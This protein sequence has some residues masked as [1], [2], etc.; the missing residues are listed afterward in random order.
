MKINR[1]LLPALFALGLVIFPPWASAESHRATRLGNPATS[2]APT[3][4]SPSDLRA[5][6]GSAE[7]HPDFVEILRQW[8]WPGNVDDMFAAAMTNEIVEW[9][10]PVGETMPFMSSREHGRPICLRNVTWAGRDPIHAYAFTFNSNGHNWRCITP[11][12]CSNFFVEDL[13]VA[14]VNALTIDCSAPDKAG[15]GHSIQLCLNVHNTG[16][17]TATN[18]SVGL[19]IP[20][21]AFATDTTDDGIVTNGLVTWIL[22]VLP[23]NSTKEVC[24]A[25][26]TQEPGTVDFSATASSAE[27]APVS[28]TCGTEVK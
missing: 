8:G 10:I 4:Y 25:V 2:F 6:F 16:N 7:L 15:V 13:G 12:P 21:T 1:Y 28:S 9:N 23:A 5:R 26:K 14:T 20:A 27:V 19:T 24:T 22:P 18:V 11:K 3:I 17:L